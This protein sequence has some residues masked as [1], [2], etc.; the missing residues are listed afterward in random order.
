[1]DAAESAVTVRE[2]A[3]S[4]LYIDVGAGGAEIRLRVSRIG[5]PAPNR[6]D[7]YAVAFPAQALAVWCGNDWR[8]R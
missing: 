6:A 5:V 4:G 2:T 1:M 7:P 3:V 8:R